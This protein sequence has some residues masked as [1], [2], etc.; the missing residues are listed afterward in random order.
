MHHYAD[1]DFRS[2]AYNIILTPHTTRNQSQ[3]RSRSHYCDS[4]LYLN[5]MTLEINRRYSGVTDLKDP[6]SPNHIHSTSVTGHNNTCLD[7]RCQSGIL[8]VSVNPGAVRSDIWRFVP[9]PL[10]HLYDLMMRL[11]YLTVEQGSRI[12]VAA[13]VLSTADIRNRKHTTASDVVTGGR[14]LVPYLVPYSMYLSPIATE[15]L[16]VYMGP[17]WTAP[18][19]PENALTV[20]SDLWEFSGLLCKA[21]LAKVGVNNIEI[22]M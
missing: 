19:L 7:D 8:A 22:T 6:F 21:A 11:L 12:S 5:L 9:A 17:H 20:S 18:S 1:I 14:S 4:K 2:S 16:G 15:M 13:A 10:S 3:S